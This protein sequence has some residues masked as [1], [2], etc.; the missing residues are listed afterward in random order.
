MKNQYNK[1]Y[2]IWISRTFSVW[3]PIVE[4]KGGVC[5]FWREMSRM[6]QNG[7]S[8]TEYWILSFNRIYVTK[9][10]KNV[11]PKKGAKEDKRAKPKA[12]QN[13]SRKVTKIID[14]H[15]GEI[16][17]VKRAVFCFV[18]N[19]LSKLYHPTFCIVHIILRSA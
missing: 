5:L 19:N 18:H 10:S 11:T 7:S 16:L 13:K 2:S 6:C 15:K 1:P 3:R 9:L 17:F 14:T 8:P 12:S 4:R